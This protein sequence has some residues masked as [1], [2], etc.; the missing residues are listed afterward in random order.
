MTKAVKRT[1]PSQSRARDLIN[2]EALIKDLQN[3][4]LDPKATISNGYIGG[5]RL[6]LDKALPS[7]SS[8]ELQ[9]ALDVAVTEITVTVKNEAKL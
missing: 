5:I 9:G 7:L 6:L 2:A 4:V 1:Y 8:V 3:K